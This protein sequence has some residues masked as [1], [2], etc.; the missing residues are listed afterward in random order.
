MS[1]RVGELIEKRSCR[2]VVGSVLTAALAAGSLGIPASQAVAGVT[3]GHRLPGAQDR[4]VRAR[5][6]DILRVRADLRFDMEREQIKGTA[7]IRFAPL[8]TGLRSLELDAFGLNI[9]SVKAVGSGAALKWKADGPKLLL[10]LP[11]VLAPGEATEVLIAYS[12]QP[13]SGLY[14][15]PASASKAAQA[16]NFGEG[17][18]HYGWLPMYNDTND[19]FAVE[20]RITVAAPL[21]ALSNGVLK[22]TTTNRDG[23]RTYR[24]V[25]DEPIP[26]YL[27]ALKVGDFK[28]VKLPS[29]RLGAKNVPLSVWTAPGAER[30]VAENFGNTPRMM[31]YFSKLLDYPYPWVKYDQVTLREFGGAM[32][33]TS[34]VGF[35]DIYERGHGDPIDSSPAF[36]LPWPIWQTDDT[37]SHELA[38]HWFGDLVTCRSLGSIWLNESFATYMHTVWNGH[39][40]GEDDLTYQRWRYLHFYLDDVQATGEVLPLE[41]L[42]YDAPEDMYRESLTYIKGSLVIHMLRR[43]VGDEDFYR[44]LNQYLKTHALGNVEARDLQAAFES[45]TGRDLNW[46]FNDWIIG[47]GGHPAIKAQTRWS[48]E[49]RQLDLTL[50]QVQSDLPFENKFRLPVEVTVFTE[51]GSATH[52]VW[53]EDWQTRVTLPA[54]TAPI[55]VSVDAG[56]WLV[57]DIHL[58]QSLSALTYLLKNGDVAAGLRAARQL[59]ADYP[60]REESLTALADVLADT[61]RHWGLRQEAAISLGSIGQTA[62]IDALAKASTDPDRRVRRGVAVALGKTNGA[63]SSLT[64]RAMVEKDTAEDVIAAAAFSLGRTHAKEARSFLVQQLERDSQWWN[65]IRTGAM[66]GLAELEDPTLVPTFQKYL[67]PQLQ[68]HL[69]L[70]ALDGWFR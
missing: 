53:M 40:K 6:V 34:M 37:I 11:A 24:W 57:A 58:E 65:A 62:A 21:I 12:A 27:I 44:A 19:R 64:L 39:S 66:L 70:A 54:G 67:A 42:Y 50:N 3:P 31:E 25:Q 45:T 41:R 47:G 20:F 1:H 26:N 59:A 15:H 38:H 17:G 46:F 52:T 18:L 14:F 28:Q 49:R 60:R 9:E 32:E 43:I 36:D 51:Q 2:W 63:Q 35:P 10:D 48:A 16:W 29:A 23:T 33:T 30:K 61:K 8:Q 22:E 5:Q 7:Q 13:R 55:A 69:R 56:N 4:P 68:R